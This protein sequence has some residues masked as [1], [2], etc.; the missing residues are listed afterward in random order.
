MSKTAPH[1]QL[2]IWTDTDPDEHLE[3]DFNIWYDT[4][5][6]QERIAIPG[7][8]YARRFRANDGG[9]RPYLALYITD[10]LDV[11]RS[12]PYQHAFTHQTSWSLACFSRMRDTQR[13]VGELV[14]ETGNGEGAQLALFVLPREAAEASEWQTLFKAGVQV[15][16]VHAVRLFYTAP[17]LSGPLS[18]AKDSAAAQPTADALVLIEGSDPAATRTVAEWLAQ[19]AGLAKAEVRTFDLLWRIGA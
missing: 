14:L 1:G 12:E 10:T 11:F 3:A 19:K 6:M 9:P 8:R 5:H 18:A 17:S 4:E 15:P 13:R 7:F 2:C 16:G